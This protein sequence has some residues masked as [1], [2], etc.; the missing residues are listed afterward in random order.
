[1]SSKDKGSASRPKSAQGKAAGKSKP[2]KRLGA[3]QLDGL[4]LDY[5][6]RHKGKLPLSRTAVP[7]GPN[8][9]RAR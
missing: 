8:A 7:K 4:V 3:E 2:P 5:M 1:M 6:K 9:H